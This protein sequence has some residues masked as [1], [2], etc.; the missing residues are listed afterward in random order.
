MYNINLEANEKIILIQEK[1]LITKNKLT[2]VALTNKRILFLDNFAESS[3]VLRIS[4]G[5]DYIKE[6][7]VYF[8]I[9]LGKVELKNNKLI[10]NNDIYI[11][12]INI[13][14]EYKGLKENNEI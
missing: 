8:S 14:N 2:T 5:V 10:I 4:N 9:E 7:D 13:I 6:Q 3:E 12:D 11:T 1:I